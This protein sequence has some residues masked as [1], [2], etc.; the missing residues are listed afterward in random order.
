MIKL[1]DVLTD[2]VTGNPFL[3]FGL[4]HRLLNLSQTAKYLQP[5]VAAQA[6]KDV[7]ASALLMALSR[8]QKDL[9]KTDLQ[10]EQFAFENIAIHGG[11]ATFTYAKTEEV[12]KGAYKLHTTVQKENKYITI[13]EGTSQV[14]II[15]ESTF[16]PLVR[17]LIS[18]KPQFVHNNVSSIG[19]A[20]SK[21]YIA[22]PGLIYIIV[23]QLMLMNINIIEVSSTFTEFVL[24]IADEDLKM[25]FE[26][27]HS[28]FHQATPC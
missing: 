28:L 1:S 23:Q 12:L 10:R 3:Q 5:V 26:A 16:S 8:L 13:S 15:V 21:D 14:T 7:K 25:A 20:F 22:V 19:I 6:K 24:Y 2:I 18:Q 9:K 17:K 11:L 4:Q 27:L